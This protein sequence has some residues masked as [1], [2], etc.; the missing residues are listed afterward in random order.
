[1]QAT[2]A[3]SDPSIATNDANGRVTALRF[4]PVTITASFQGRSATRTINVVF[5]YG[6]T[7]TGTYAVR[8]CDQ[9]GIFLSSRYCQN[10]SLEPLPLSLE[11]TQTGPWAA[12]IGG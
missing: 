10:A 1:T 11:L 3:T 8:A 9:T 5:N 2:Q 12:R 4:G 7:W 6:G